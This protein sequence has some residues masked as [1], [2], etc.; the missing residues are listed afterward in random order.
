M[1]QGVQ[2]DPPHNVSMDKIPLIAALLAL[3]TVVDAQVPYKIIEP[4]PPIG[5]PEAQAEMEKRWK[6]AELK[7]PTKEQ[8]TAGDWMLVMM[9]FGGTGF[10]RETEVR[11][12]FV[13]YLRPDGTKYVRASRSHMG[14]PVIGG[15]LVDFKTD[16]RSAS[17]EFKADFADRTVEIDYACRIIGETVLQCRTG[18]GFEGFKRVEQGK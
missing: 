9:Q 12:R 7:R 1:A 4:I 5:T 6:D 10:Y 14:A 13:E 15:G 11:L 8:L 17:F 2:A 18:G 16:A 3:V